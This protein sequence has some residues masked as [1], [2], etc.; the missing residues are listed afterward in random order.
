MSSAN[1]G[2]AAWLRAGATA[3]VLDLL[4]RNGDEGRVVGGAVRNALMG[5]PIGDIDIATTMAPA[6]V[7]RRARGAG[8]KCVPT[9]IEHG[10]VTLVIDGLPFEVTTLRQDVETFGRKA[11][12][13]FGADWAIDAQR[14][15]FTVNAL[16]VSADGVVHDYV[17][18]LPDIAARRIR[19][20]GDPDERIAEDY[21]R[22]LRFFRI[23]AGYG[24]GELDRE[25]LRACIRGRGGIAGLSAERIRAEMLKLVVADGAL[26]VVTTMAEIGLLQQIFGGM[27]YPNIFAGLIRAERAMAL[28]PV[29]I[30]RLAALAVGVTEDAKRLGARLRLTNA[31]TKALDSM[32]HR[33]WRAAG[34]SEALAKRRLYRIGVERFRERTLLA[35][36][37]AGRNADPEWWTQLAMLPERWTAPTFPIKA[38]D[39]I[40]RGVAAGPALGHAITLAE[41]AWL[42][43]D[44]PDDPAVL[45]DIVDQAIAR[46]SR[47]TPR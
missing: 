5:L 39:F 17:D 30:R 12:V 8:I 24:A 2:D 46:I 4:N 11:K 22:V 45:S 41:D 23:H 21:L 36:A 47:D 34:A 19:F 10:T 32:G 9:G 37:R 31:E 18:G 44:F 26:P 13:E 43:L 38:A 20:I 40:A 42:G 1:L 25:G 16:S 35:W 29:A 27:A 6:D 14:R 28:E 15:D 7:V 3:R 33:W